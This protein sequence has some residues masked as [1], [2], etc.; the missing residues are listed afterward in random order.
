MSDDAFIDLLLVPG[1]LVLHISKIPIPDM[2][3]QGFGVG[4]TFRFERLP[5]RGSFDRIAY[6][7]S[8]TPWY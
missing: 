8:M 2:A 1:Q 7:I 6:R 3:G 4:M 5:G